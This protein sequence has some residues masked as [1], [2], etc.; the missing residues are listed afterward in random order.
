MRFITD[1]LG[2]TG[3]GAGYEK[4]YI[5]DPGKAVYK[6]PSGVSIPFD[7]EDVESSIATKAAAFES[8]SGNGTYVQHNGHTS[9]RFPMVA[10]FHGDG[11][12]A[13]ARAFV[14]AL[15][16]PGVGKLTHPSYPVPISV[17]PF[18]EIR[19]VEPLKSAANQAKISVAFWETT[20]LKIG[21]EGS[22]SQL[23]DSFEDAASIDFSEKIRLDTAAD[24]NGFLSKIQNTVGKISDA[25][26]KASEGIGNAT[27]GI[28]TIGASING[29]LDLLMGQP[30][31]LARQMQILVTEPRRQLKGIKAKFEGYKNL[32][33]DIFAND[34]TGL[35]T[36]S[37]EDIN[38]FH[39]NK[40]MAASIVG[41]SGAMLSGGDEDLTRADYIRNADDLRTLLDDF[42]DWSDA[43]YDAMSSAELIP[44]A[45]DTGGG[46]LGS[47]I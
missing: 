39:L 25:M 17:V 31:A 43:G 1:F 26:T 41:N 14:G 21:A 22:I 20:G 12:E 35:S 16:E 19:T 30:L 24:R 44:D 6:S 18:G 47:S 5:R 3:G 8:A 29:G 34:A 27:Q 9:G 13:K 10:I 2:I 36:Y 15:L 28:E 38:D 7:Y 32:A 23:Y 33:N 40:L 4:I 37:N 42:Q 46:R 45:L 11:Y